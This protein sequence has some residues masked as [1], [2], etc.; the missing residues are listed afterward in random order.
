M[1]YKLEKN[2]EI[3]FIGREDELHQFQSLE[4][5]PSANLVVINGRRRIG[6]SRLV[7]EFAK[8]KDYYAFSGLA[9]YDGMTAQ[10]Q[11]DDFCNT[12]TKLTSLPK[13]QIEN[14]PDLF[15]LLANEVKQGQK[16][17]LFDEI[18][19]MAYGSPDFLSHL[20]KAWDEMF[21]LN[22]NLILVLCG[23]VSSWIEKNILSGTGFFGRPSLHI[24]LTE[25]SLKH[26]NEFWG[27]Y[28]QNISSYEKL[29]LLS[30]TGGVPRYLELINPR[31]SAEANFKRLCFS[32]NGILF[33]EFKKI[34]SDIYGSRSQIY[35]NIIRYLCH[36]PSAELSEISEHSSIKLGGNLS[37]YLDDLK[38]GGFI[39]RD[40]SWN[41]QSGTPS[42]KSKYRLKDNFCRFYLKYVEPNAQK[43]EQG[44]FD[45]GSI[46]NLPGWDTIMGYQFE[47]L[48][49]NNPKILLKSLDIPLSDVVFA[50]PYFQKKTQRHQDCQ[51]DY[52]IQT[53]FNTVYICEIKFKRKPVGAELIEEVQAKAEKLKLPKQTSIRPVL[54]HV[55]GID[56]HADLHL[57]FSNIIDFGTCFN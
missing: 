54:I 6:K 44:L 18:S 30:L 38:T 19:W 27:T 26:C 42:A 15:S 7:R 10:S 11:R 2:K 34:F 41:F 21:S 13:L 40:Y 25:L 57:Y 43:I 20:K 45:E 37:E 50:G 24:N 12:L 1:G 35:T 9:P 31:E 33:T 23:S 55:N 51:I 14:W 56:P 28:S 39:S 16:V 47:N 53:R 29:K 17:I 8:N 52:L 3:K 36:H 22:P 5:L 48:V 49:I 4:D 32:K 46:A